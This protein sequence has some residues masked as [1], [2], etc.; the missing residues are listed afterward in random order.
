MAKWRRTDLGAIPED[1]AATSKVN[2]Q[3]VTTRSANGAPPASNGSEKTQAGGC[4]TASSATA[5]T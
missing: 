1:Y 3:D 2:G 4:H 5:L